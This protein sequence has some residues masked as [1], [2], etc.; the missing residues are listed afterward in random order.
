MAKGAMMLA[1][2]GAMMLDAQGA[3]EL[4]SRMQDGKSAM[5][6]RSL[7]LDIQCNSSYT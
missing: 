5:G 2:K 4:A 6:S 1:A 7:S 3:T